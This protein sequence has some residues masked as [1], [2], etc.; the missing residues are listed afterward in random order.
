MQSAKP[1]TLFARCVSVGL[2]EHQN[3]EASFSASLWA[4]TPRMPLALAKHVLQPHSPKSLRN[5]R[6][7]R[8]WTTTSKLQTAGRTCCGLHDIVGLCRQAC[9]LAWEGGSRPGEACMDPSTASALLRFGVVHC[10][11]V[12]AGQLQGGPDHVQQPPCYKPT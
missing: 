9:L 6:D 8:L 3:R 1:S 11:S 12:L 5:A 2:L 4:A 7:V 10:W